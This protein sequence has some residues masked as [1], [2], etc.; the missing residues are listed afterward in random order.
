MYHR[1]LVLNERKQTLLTHAERVG[2]KEEKAEILK[3]LRDLHSNYGELQN[4]T[5]QL[6][7]EKL[8]DQIKMHFEEIAKAITSRLVEI[9]GITA[10]YPA[11][12]PWQ[13]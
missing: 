5:Y 10:N 1:L 6:L 13:K 3:R 7:S 4:L 8:P 11:V 9:D 12:Y 2:S